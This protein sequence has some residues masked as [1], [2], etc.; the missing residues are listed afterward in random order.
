MDT[1]GLYDAAHE[2]HHSSNYAE[3]PRLEQNTNS[4][5]RIRYALTSKTYQQLYMIQ[6]N[7]SHQNHKDQILPN[8]HQHPEDKQNCRVKHPVSR[9]LYQRYSTRF[10][11]PGC[12]DA[13]RTTPNT[14]SVTLL[15]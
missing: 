7:A 2:E 8:I 11:N 4:T 9:N 5:Q 1:R 12:F 10:A 6:Q 3:L 14:D 13:S 15:E